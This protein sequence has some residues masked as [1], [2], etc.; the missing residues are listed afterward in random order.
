MTEDFGKKAP[1]AK[2]RI[3]VIRGGA[4]GD[5][6][7]T[8]P[9]IHNLTMGSDRAHLGVIGSPHLQR[10]ASPDLFIDQTSSECTW[11]FDD[12]E[13]VV[14][15][16][17]SGQLLATANLILAYSTHGDDSTLV[18][19]L[20][21]LCPGTV[22]PWDPRPVT[23]DCHI[24]DH[25]LKP[26]EQAKRPTPNWVPSIQ[27]TEAELARGHALLS[28]REDERLVV[29]LHPGSGGSEKR[30]PLQSFHELAKRLTEN[31]LRC[32]M[33]CG[34]VEIDSSPVMRS[35]P[36]VPLIRQE[37]L[38]DL[39]GLTAAADLFIGNDSGPA[40]V[41][42]AVGTPTVALFGPTNPLIWRP[43]AAPSQVVCAPDGKLDALEV[44]DVF[45]AVQ[46][47]MSERG[48]RRCP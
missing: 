39:I 46:S 15:D 47:I 33:V 11:L 6:V 48:K 18:R 29:I 26:L 30:W 45:V 14:T 9:A 42:A 1:R 40:H 19:K 4:L 10:L 27:E 36:D 32:A 24:G 20:E 44:V 13:N 7:V 25:L 37:C 35:P 41:A 43:L 22:L 31:G 23:E 5:G 2:E 17:P 16:S 21:T 28:T 3:A 38:S 12:T 8:L 34:P